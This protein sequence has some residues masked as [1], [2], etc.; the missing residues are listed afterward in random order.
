MYT[1]SMYVN[2]VLQIVASQK[3]LLHSGL[4]LVSESSSQARYYWAAPRG[5]LI[6]ISRAVF[7]SSS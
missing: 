1:T 7:M 5:I 3:L 4:E 2:I 6:S